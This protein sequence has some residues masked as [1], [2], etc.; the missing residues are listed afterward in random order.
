MRSK[1][2]KKVVLVI[3]NHRRTQVIFIDSYCLHDPTRSNFSELLFMG[4]GETVGL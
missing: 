2:S 4:S 3:Q 1:I